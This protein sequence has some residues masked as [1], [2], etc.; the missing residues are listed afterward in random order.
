MSDA[1]E[2]D[3][4]EG[5]LVYVHFS[6]FEKAHNLRYLANAGNIM[7]DEESLDKEQARCKIDAMMM[8][9]TP[10]LNLG[11]QAFFKT[12]VGPRGGDV[13]VCGIT[14]HRINF[15][16]SKSDEPAVALAQD[17]DD[18]EEEAYTATKV[19]AKRKKQAPRAEE[20]GEGEGD[21]N[22]SPPKKGRGRPKGSTKKQRNKENDI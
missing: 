7:L 12:G 14:E 15:E 5:E 21:E 1:S 19:T 9:G 18:E 10:M 2:S 8:V 6:D 3:S 22:P 13:E 20:E 16:V 17:E 11:S 4:N